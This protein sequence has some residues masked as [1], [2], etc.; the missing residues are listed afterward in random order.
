MDGESAQTIYFDLIFMMH[1]MFNSCKLVHADL[2]EYN[3]LVYKN[4]PY[5]IDVSQ[6]VEQEH[7]HAFDFL[8]SD[9]RNVT[10]FFRR[11]A[12]KTFS[13]KELFQFVTREVGKAIDY[14]NLEDA[15]SVQEWESI[16]NHILSREFKSAQDIDIDDAVFLQSFIPRTLEEVIDVEGDVEKLAIGDSDQFLYKNLIHKAQ[17]HDDDEDD[18]DEH[19]EDDDDDEELSDEDDEEILFSSKAMLDDVD[20]EELS[21]EEMSDDDV[22]NDSSNPVNE[23]VSKEAR[24]LHKKQVKEENRVRRA[25]SKLSKSEKKRVIKKSTTKKKK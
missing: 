22:S 15:A 1:K 4:R 16:M 8:R 23:A 21:D 11:R 9:C 10:D 5:I 25:T 19:D 20:D 7:P 12:C 18:D 24:K 17:D 3:I 6:S 14:L 13:I 2:S